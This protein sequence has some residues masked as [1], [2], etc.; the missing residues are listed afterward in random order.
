[1]KKFLSI[2]LAGAMFAA[3]GVCT[4][5]G[6]VDGPKPPDDG[7]VTDT[8]QLSEYDYTLMNLA[9]TDGLG[10]RLET[11]DN[12]RTETKYVGLFYSV[13][14]G[15]HTDQQTDIYDVN[16]LLS[17]A[18]G[19]AALEDTQPNAL[20]RPDEFHFSGQPLYGYYSM[21][22]PWVINRHVELLTLTGIDYLCIDA[23]N[24]ILYQLPTTTLLD[25]LKK[26]QDQGW[27]VPKVMFYTNSNSGVTVKKLY[28]DFYQ[29]GKYDALWWNVNGKPMIIGITENKRNASD[30]TKYD[31]TYS[32]FISDEMQE[33]FDVWESQWPNGDLNLEKGIPWM[34]WQNPQVIH[35]G[36]KSISVSV[37][38]HSHT[39]INMSSRDPECSRGYDYL[40]GTVEGNYWEGRNFQNEWNDV[41]NRD[42]QIENVMVTSFNEWMAIKTMSGG[43][44][45]FC[46]VFTEEYSRDIEM[47]AGENGDHFFMQLAENVKK[48]KFTEGSVAYEWPQMSIDIASESALVMWEHVA[49]KY[50]DFEGDA[51]ARDYRNAVGSFRYTDS[52]NRNDITDVRAVH[53]SD[54]LYFYIKTAEDITP[55]N[56]TDVNWMNLLISTSSEGGFAGYQYIINRQ[57]GEGKTSVERSLGGYEWTSA[58]EAQ[59][60]I[61][62][63]VMVV[64][65]PL[66][67]LGLTA[68]SCHIE[69]KVSDN[70]TKYDDIM[71]YYVSGDSA[72]IG[73]FSYSYG[74]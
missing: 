32:D 7:R 66:S 11:A 43:T 48:Y 65:V 67:A 6:S 19:V 53:D 5:C 25:T 51:M 49:A 73:R 57:P 1:M 12:Y 71:D 74:K 44:Y 27:R 50:K 54:N 16:V 8:R 13:W 26:Y 41:F 14:L 60:R 22:D 47:S 38:Q 52:S 28:N 72:P 3:A 18:E 33:Y 24:S 61:Y 4:A 68:E 17:T 2:L 29:T 23:T 46:D 39:S 56:G 30:Q 40:T 20:S 36:S 31:P 70:V 37:A 9:A 35:T 45:N 62:G 10:R 69:F 21:S 59:Y 58:G 15:Q 63:N 55:W 64:A 34:S 42:G